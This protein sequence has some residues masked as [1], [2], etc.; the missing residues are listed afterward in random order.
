MWLGFLSPRV[1][2]GK[3]EKKG[4]RGWKKPPPPP[5]GKKVLLLTLEPVNT[6]TNGPWKFGRITE[7]GVLTGRVKFQEWSMLNDMLR[8]I[9]QL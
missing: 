3:G 4:V 7:V 2:Q 5:H 9:S 1:P 6:V 8:Y